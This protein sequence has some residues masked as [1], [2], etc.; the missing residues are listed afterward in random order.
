MPSWSQQ[1]IFSRGPKH[2]GRFSRRLK[3]ESRA[4]VEPITSE[5]SHQICE[6]LK[7]TLV[8]AWEFGP[9]D[10]MS[11]YACA[12]NNISTC[13][14]LVILS[15]LVVTIWC[16]NQ[17]E[18]YNPHKQLTTLLS[19]LVQ[20][21]KLHT[22]DQFHLVIFPFR[23]F[24]SF[25]SNSPFEQQNDVISVHFVQRNFITFRV[26]RRRRGNVYWSRAFVCLCVC[27][28]PYSRTIARTRVCP[29]VVHYWADLQLVRGFRCYN[30]LAPR[31]MAIDAHDSISANVKCQRVHRCIPGSY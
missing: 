22:A 3:H 1:G 16:I 7:I 6:N 27:S 18:F 9:V 5:L 21:T 13:H 17:G 2:I 29:L 11:S 19:K 14:K 15:Q 10:P 8:V 20:Y 12:G 28:S 25:Q 31:V 26:S 24:L 23:K 4:A 30:N